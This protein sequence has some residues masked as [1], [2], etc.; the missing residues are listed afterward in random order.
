MGSSMTEIEHEIKKLENIAQQIEK[1]FGIVTGIAE[2]TNLLSLNASIESARAGE[3]GKGFAVVANEVRKLS[4]DTKKT[5]SAVSELV[6]NTNA[7]ISI[8]TRHITDVNQLVK[9]SKRK[10]SDIN[11]LFDDIVS[12]MKTSKHQSGRIEGDLQSFLSG[13]EEVNGAV[14]QVASSVDSLVEL[15]KK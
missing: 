3:H 12:N 7:Q 9:E 2:Q 13:L 14:L 10:M 1:I 15:T 5:V 8:V 11:H 6:N 4:D